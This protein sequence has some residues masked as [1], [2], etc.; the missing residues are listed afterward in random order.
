PDKEQRG[1]FRPHEALPDGVAEHP[2]E[3]VPVALDVEH[4]DGL[5]VD[6]E[7]RPRQDL[8][9]LFEGAE[10]AGKRDEPVG[11]P[12]H[13]RLPFVHRAHHPELREPGVGELARGEW[14]RNH[15][16]HLAALGEDRVGEHAHEAHRAAAVDEPEPRSQMRMSS[17]SR[18]RGRANWTFVRLGKAGWV[19]M[20]GPSRRH[21]AS[22]RR[23]TNVTQCGLPTETAVTRSVVPSASWS[24]T[25]T[26]SRS[27]PFI[28]ISGARNVARP[29]STVTKFTRPSRTW[30]WHSTRP[31]F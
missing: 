19:S 21:S 3:P 5:P 22:S 20:S 28:G 13:R 4:A 8:E 11:E 10:A 14:S 26:T 16:D 15:A 27:G 30:H 1:V 6:P 23:S 25:P 24:G 29:I 31:P 7:L 9:R 18:A 17:V 12:G 2:L